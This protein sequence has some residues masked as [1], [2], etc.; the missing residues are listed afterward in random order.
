MIRK[1]VERDL[2]AVSAIYE[3]IHRR[4]EAGLGST[5]WKR[6]VYPTR[7]TARAALAAGELFVDAR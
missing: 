1:A 3:R 2:P 4:E 6:G 5:G 7:E